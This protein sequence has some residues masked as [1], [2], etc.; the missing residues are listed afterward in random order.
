MY[1]LFRL[2]FMSDLELLGLVDAGLV[3]AGEEGILHVEQLVNLLR[4]GS[5]GRHSFSNRN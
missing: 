5:S 4:S 3:V 1:R 2:V